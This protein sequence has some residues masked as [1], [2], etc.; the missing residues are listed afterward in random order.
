MFREEARL[1]EFEWRAQVADFRE[2]SFAGKRKANSELGRKSVLTFSPSF[3]LDCR[4]VVLPKALPHIFPAVLAQENSQNHLGMR[5]NDDSF[6]NRCVAF[7]WDV[8]PLAFDHLVTDCLQKDER[9]AVQTAS[10]SVRFRRGRQDEHY[11][12]ERPCRHLPEVHP[13][14]PAAQPALRRGRQRPW[15][16]GVLKAEH[17]ALFA[18]SGS[19]N[20]AVATSCGATQLSA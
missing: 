18:N 2:A 9:P 8:E 13:L 19:T 1:G 15:A 10:K 7:D 5:R 17:S 3:A 6:W 14:G 16:E 20:D 11:L 4:F 12:A